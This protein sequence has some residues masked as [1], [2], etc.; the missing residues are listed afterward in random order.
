MSYVYD[1]GRI[2]FKILNSCCLFVTF[3]FIMLITRMQKQ[4]NESEKRLKKQNQV[5]KFSL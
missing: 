3:I 5:R 2:I 1:V 4:K